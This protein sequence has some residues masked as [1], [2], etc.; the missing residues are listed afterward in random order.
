M[1]IRADRPRL[2]RSKSASVSSV[3]CAQSRNFPRLEIGF[4][5]SCRRL[6]Y[7]SLGCRGETLGQRDGFVPERRSMERLYMGGHW[8][9][10]S[11]REAGVSER[12][13]CAR[14][15][16]H[17]TSLR[18]GGHWGRVSARETLYQRD[19]FVLERRSMERLYMGVGIGGEL[20]SER[21]CIRETALC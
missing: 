17:G 21:R 2:Y 15:T 6:C 8:G 9:R 3:K 7:I 18:W 16:F 20:V 11:A 14:E 4:A 5:P 12:R 1:R 19:G 13:L 10:V